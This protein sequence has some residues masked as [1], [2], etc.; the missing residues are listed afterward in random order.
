MPTV[1]VY[2]NAT[3]AVEH[4]ERG[5]NERMPYNVGGTLTVREFRAASCSDILWTDRRTM[6][7]WNQTR[8]AFGRPIPVGYAFRRIWEGGHSGQSQHYAGT[9]FDVG[10][11]LSAASRRELHNA[12]L[13]TGAWSY[14]EPLSMTPT[15]VHF[16]ARTNP[17][18]CA[19]GG[20]PLVRMGSRGVYVFVLQDALN[21]LGY[22]GGGLDGIFGAGVENAVRRFQRDSGFYADGI[23]GC[24]TWTALTSRV[25]GMGS[26]PTVI[27]RC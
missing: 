14:V 9:S 5:L 27:G 13:A 1:Y 11:V 3:N 24:V 18:A 19:R 26:T 7:A 16:D 6:G 10:Q 2:N 23:V 20:Y 15:W 12:A 8:D 21:A 17:P 22:T 4:Y 25:N